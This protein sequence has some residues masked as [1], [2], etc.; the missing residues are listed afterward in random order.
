M[1][2]R[3]SPSC[4]R[5][6][7]PH[8]N[9]FHLLYGCPCIQVFAG[10]TKKIGKCRLKRYTDTLYGY[11]PESNISQALSHYVVIAKYH[12]FL[13]C[14]NKTYPSFEIFSFL[15][16]EKILCEHTTTFK[17]ITLGKFSAKWTQ[18]VHE[19][20]QISFSQGMCHS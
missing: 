5:C 9:L 20:R 12:I 14:L 4:D 15:P 2:L 17:N 6:S 10:G 13:S 3:T 16:N 8:E 18:Y 1:K 19:L 7:H 11:K